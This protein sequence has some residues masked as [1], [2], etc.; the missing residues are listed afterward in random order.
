LR[1]HIVDVQHDYVREFLMAGMRDRAE[2]DSNEHGGNRSAFFVVPK[3]RN[4][5]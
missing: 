2:V 1:A 4:S 3:Y 5:V